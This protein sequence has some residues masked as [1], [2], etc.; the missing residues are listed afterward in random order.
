MEF[1][2]ILWSPRLTYIFGWSFSAENSCVFIDYVPRSESYSWRFICSY[3]VPEHTKLARLRKLHGAGRETLPNFLHF[4]WKFEEKSCLTTGG[5]TEKPFWKMCLLHQIY[6]LS[7][8]DWS[9]IFNYLDSNHPVWPEATT[10]TLTN[11]LNA[12]L[13]HHVYLLA[14]TLSL[15]SYFTYGVVC[16][17]INFQ[18]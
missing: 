1:T 14:T 3:P 18:C 10:I 16:L 8:F 15:Q 17:G 11:F 5:R 13:W 12:R 6:H 7:N 9:N 2:R 4:L